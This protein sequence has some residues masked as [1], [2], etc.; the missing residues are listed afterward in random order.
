MQ[1][2]SDSNSGLAL[3]YK[4]VPINGVVFALTTLVFLRLYLNVPF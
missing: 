3:S 4:M 2:N 1:S